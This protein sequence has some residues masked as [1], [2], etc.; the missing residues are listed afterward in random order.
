MVSQV[1]EKSIQSV[2]ANALLF[3]AIGVSGLAS[4]SNAF[5]KESGVIGTNAYQTQRDPDQQPDR[6]EKM[7][8]AA[9]RRQEIPEATLPCSPDEAKWWEELRTAGNRARRGRDKDPNKFHELLK[10]G[11]DKSFQAPIPNRGPTFL[12][13]FPPEYSQEARQFQITGSIAMVVEFLPDGAV[14]EVRIVQGLGYGM[15]EKAAEAARKSVFLPAVK[16]AHFVSMRVPMTMSFSI[17]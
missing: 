17:R 2:C 5:F 1:I 11:R 8:L 6:D 12:R 10:E 15:D 16:D 13:K 3:F 7:A 14:G 4:T 9:L